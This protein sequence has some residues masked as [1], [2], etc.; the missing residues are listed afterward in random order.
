[1]ARRKDHVH[2]E[3]FS[4]HDS[5]DLGKNIKKQISTR[6]KKAKP[7]SKNNKINICLLYQPKK[8]LNGSSYCQHHVGLLQICHGHHKS[9]LYLYSAE[10]ETCWDRTGEGSPSL[11]FGVLPS[12]DLLSHK[13]T[14]LKEQVEVALN[15][16]IFSA[17]ELHLLV[18]HCSQAELADER[19][20]HCQKGNY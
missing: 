5:L 18:E 1:M 15:E 4:D 6:E 11:V 3:T 7:S 9:S 16:M 2:M 14:D 13:K 10:N 19:Q 12:G 8:A 17:R 20:V